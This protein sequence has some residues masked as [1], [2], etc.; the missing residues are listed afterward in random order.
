MWK[1]KINIKNKN[2]TLSSPHP[3]MSLLQKPQEPPHLLLR[4]LRSLPLLC[5]QR[6]N[7]QHLL[8][9]RLVDITDSQR[10]PRTTSPLSSRMEILF[11]KFQFFIKLPEI[12]LILQPPNLPNFK[13]NQKKKKL[14]F[15]SCLSCFNGEHDGIGFSA[16]HLR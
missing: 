7:Q 15:F 1:L 10:L 12:R 14:N 5:Q 11:P 16:Q 2:K 8:P 6:P 3:L 13:L 9:F 4:A